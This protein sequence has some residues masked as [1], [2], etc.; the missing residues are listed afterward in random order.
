M[1]MT[2]PHAGVGAASRDSW[3]TSRIRRLGCDFDPD[4]VP[5]SPRGLRTTATTG[6][7]R[8][9]RRGSVS[10]SASYDATARAPVLSRLSGPYHGVRLRWILTR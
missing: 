8:G 1:E 4:G 6:H 7:P 5:Q 3:A 10:D 9:S 2:V